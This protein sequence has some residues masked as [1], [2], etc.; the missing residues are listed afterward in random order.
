LRKGDRVLAAGTET[1]LE[2]IP[3]RVVLE[4]IGRFREP[5]L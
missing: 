2:V 5:L 4:K 3:L 1:A